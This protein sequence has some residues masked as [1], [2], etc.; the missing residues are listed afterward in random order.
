M[1]INYNGKEIE[2][3]NDNDVD[4]MFE[5]QCVCGHKL[6]DH[7]FTHAYG[8]MRRYITSQCIPCGFHTVNGLVSKD[9]EHPEGFVCEQ[10]RIKPGKNDAKH[11]NF[12]GL[13]I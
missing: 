13:E 1:K 4:E 2:L 9:E 10:F 12:P 8:T 3:E 11:F 5:L 6:K 7:S